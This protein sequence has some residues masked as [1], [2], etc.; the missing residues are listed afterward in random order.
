MD[1]REARYWSRHSNV[2]VRVGDYSAD[3]TKG[4]SN[5]R[6]CNTWLTSIALENQI[7]PHKHLSILSTILKV[8]VRITRAI[9]CPISCAI[10]LQITDALWCICDLVSDKNTFISIFHHIQMRFHLRYRVQ[11][12][13]HTAAD[14]K[15]HVKSHMK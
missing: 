1:R 15:S 9:L 5:I 4:E 6:E 11:C 14:I 13:T 3:G 8:K 10:C 2:Q 7:C 12:S